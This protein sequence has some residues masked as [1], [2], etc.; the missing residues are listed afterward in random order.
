LISWP[1]GRAQRRAFTR[2][3]P[4]AMPAAPRTPNGGAQPKNL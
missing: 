1:T 3:V 4:E 2:D